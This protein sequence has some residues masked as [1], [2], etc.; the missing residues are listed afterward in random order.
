MGGLFG[1]KPDT[2]KQEA[3][4]RRQLQMQ[5]AQN[6]KLS[7]KERKERQAEGA[8]TRALKGRTGRGI[9]SNDTLYGSFLGVPK[10]G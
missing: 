8:R 7:E 9:G 1:S 4:Q 6:A 3:M 2:S 10:N 5:E